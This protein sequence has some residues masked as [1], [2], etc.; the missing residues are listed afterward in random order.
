MFFLRGFLRGL[1][2]GAEGRGVNRVLTGSI[3]G[4]FAGVFAGVE[5]ICCFPF[6]LIVS[7]SS[8][9]VTSFCS[10]VSMFFRVTLPSAISL[11]PAR[12]T[13]GIALAFA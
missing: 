7:S 9:G 5:R 8:C 1:R 6:Y 3:A 10:P 12:A 11:S 2:K 13:K 4:V